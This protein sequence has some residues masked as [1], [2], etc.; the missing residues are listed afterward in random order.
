MYRDQSNVYE[1]MQPIFLPFKGEQ[2]STNVYVYCDCKIYMQIYANSPR[3]DWDVGQTELHEVTGIGTRLSTLFPL[4]V[5]VC[6]SHCL[7]R[8]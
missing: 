5:S 3:L 1:I 4:L 6:F 2:Q 7:V 8:H